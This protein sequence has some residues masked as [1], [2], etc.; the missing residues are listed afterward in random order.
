MFV[1]NSYNQYLLKETSIE[2]LQQ[3]KEK[4][5]HSNMAQ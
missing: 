5:I 4:M 1:S 2:N 3:E